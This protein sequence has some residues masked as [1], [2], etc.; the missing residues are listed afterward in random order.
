[1]NSNILHR[2]ISSSSA[3]FSGLSGYGIRLGK[4][5]VSS[6][7]WLWCHARQAEGGHLPV[8]HVFSPVESLTQLAPTLP[9][10]VQNPLTRAQKS[11]VLLAKQLGRL[12]RVQGSVVYRCSIA[13]TGFMC[14]PDLHC[15]MQPSLGHTLRNGQKASTGAAMGPKHAP[16]DGAAWLWKWWLKA[17]SLVSDTLAYITLSSLH[18]LTSSVIRDNTFFTGLMWGKIRYCHFNWLAH[19]NCPITWNNNNNTWVPF[20]FPQESVNLHAVTRLHHSIPVREKHNSVC[21]FQHLGS[22]K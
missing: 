7:Q 18:W 14:Q 22:M 8:C 9:F 13:E 11:L 4:A 16:Q 1:M 3:G 6:T 12:G 19:I 2:N 17:Q 10:V 21:H 20:S 15:P 5:A